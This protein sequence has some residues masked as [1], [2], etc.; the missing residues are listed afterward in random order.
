MQWVCIEA[1]YKVHILCV[2]AFEVFAYKMTKLDTKF[3]NTVFSHSI[4]PLPTEMISNVVSGHPVH[5][6]FIFTFTIN[7]Q[8]IRTQPNLQEALHHSNRT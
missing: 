6:H 8:A 1:L 7:Q 3:S 5:T 2:H 4:V